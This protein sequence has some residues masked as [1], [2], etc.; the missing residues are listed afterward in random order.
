[1]KK[2]IVNGVEKEVGDVT[3][4][5]IRAAALANKE[6]AHGPTVT[7]KKKDKSGTL[8]PGDVVLVEDGMN[9]NVAITGGA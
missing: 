5:Y 2:I 8:S 7:F 9:F 6:A 3:I 1:M 4:G